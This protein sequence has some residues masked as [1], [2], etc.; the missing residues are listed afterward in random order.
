MHGQQ[1]IKICVYKEFWVTNVGYLMWNQMESSHT[2]CRFSRQAW[3]TEF[4][5]NTLP[6]RNIWLRRFVS[7]EVYSISDSR[8][9]CVPELEIS[10]WNY[11]N[12]IGDVSFYCVVIVYYLFV[13]TYKVTFV[14]YL[15]YENWLTIAA[16]FVE[17]FC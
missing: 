3:N 9:R 17:K 6:R 15:H 8:V 2:S 12:L 7:S 13:W 1:N 10:F 4:L 11:Q 16:K 5:L 14:F